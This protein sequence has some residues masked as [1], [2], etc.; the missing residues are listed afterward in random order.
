MKRRINTMTKGIRN[1][2]L[3]LF[4][5][6]LCGLV[7]A[8]VAATQKRGQVFAQITPESLSCSNCRSG[9]FGITRG[10]T[11]RLNLVSVSDGEVAPEPCRGGDV[12]PGPCHV[13]LLFFD[14]K[15]HTLAHSTETLAPGRAVALDLNG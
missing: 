13:E 8:G 9:M 1:E 4:A 6:C 5:T 11:A 7:L 14:A 15:G 3:R 12:Q 2:M 10:Q